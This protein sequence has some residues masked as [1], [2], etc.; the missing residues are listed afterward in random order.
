MGVIED[1]IAALK[2]E[3]DELIKQYKEQ[4]KACKEQ[5]RSTLNDSDRPRLERQA[6][7]LNEQLKR[8]YDN[9]NREIERLERVERGEPPELTPEV[10]SRFKAEFRNEWEADLHEL[11]YDK[12]ENSLHKL[13]RVKQQ[14]IVLLFIQRWIRMKADLYI[15]RIRKCVFD[16]GRLRPFIEDFSNEGRVDPQRFIERWQASLQIEESE[17]GVQSVIQK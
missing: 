7:Q 11:D 8:K 4:Y 16:D 3:Q 5:A 10:L 15:K 6:E 14:E 9:L 13:V 12:P 1:Q 2:R 17:A